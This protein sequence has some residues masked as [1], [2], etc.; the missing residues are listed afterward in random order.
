MICDR[1]KAE[2]DSFDLT[3]EALVESKEN[4]RTFFDTVD[5]IIVIASTEGKILHTNPAFFSKLGYD[6]SDIHELHLLDLH[7]ESVRKD[8]VAIFGDMLGGLRDACPLPIRTKNGDHVPVET[9]VWFGKWS[10]IDCIFGI[11]KDLSKEQEALQKFDKL[12][13][14]NPALMAVSSIPERRFTDV[15]ESFLSTL[16]FSREE[17]IGKTSAELDL[18]VQPKVQAE[19]GNLIEQQG[20]VRNVDMKVRTKDARILDGLFSGDIIESQGK[21]SFLTVMVDI[22]EMKEAERALQ[23]AEKKFRSLFENSLDGIFISNTNGR[24]L[25]ANRAAC[26]LLEMGEDEICAIGR[27]EIVDTTESRFNEAL[28]V[29]ERTGGFQGELTFRKS[30]GRNFPV[31]VSSASIDAPSS[32]AQS[33][34]IFRDIT[35]RK[36]MEQERLEMERRLLQFQKLESLW[37]MAGGIAHDFNNL[38][39]AAMGNLELA[40]MELPQGS[41]LDSNISTAIRCIQRA[42]EISGK[43]LTYSGNA[44]YEKIELKLNDL[45]QNNAQKLSSLV[46]LNATLEF[47]LQDQLPSIIGDKDHVLQVIS[48]LVTNASEA[49]QGG[50][51]RIT[52]TTSLEECDRNL[53]NRS[54]LSQKPEPGQYV[55]IRVDDNGYGMDEKTISRLFDPFFRTKFVGRG[56]GLSTV[57]GI[58]KAHGGAIL[59]E[60]EVGRGSSISVLFPVPSKTIEEIPTLRKP[61][62][63]VPVRRAVNRKLILVI[64]DEELV[65][66]LIVRMVE[67]L[68]YGSCAAVNGIHGV[69]LFQKNCDQIDLVLLDLTMPEIDGTEVL[70]KLRVIKPDVRVIIMSGFNKDQ[71]ISRFEDDQPNGFVQKPYTTSE[72]RAELTRVIGG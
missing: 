22:T 17:I 29:R 4:F 47:S 23:K 59:V 71:T 44:F 63:M 25:H 36:R 65:R 1:I 19:V 55:C 37:M 51:G 20:F 15:N 8:A 67:H 58:M 40:L 13:M 39:H 53:L 18:F 38:F 56:L 9:R 7:P 30:D 32:D 28:E 26:S 27:S 14:C 3:L 41:D 68:G 52:M 11:C 62:P 16:G 61:I 43:M 69:E 72:L 48:Q 31:D 66:D 60:S 24:I 5:D 49:V 10:G 34:V 54:C 70:R 33:Y 46:S 6:K 2:H 57:M 42:S 12:F 64:E 50:V 21:K 45:I 35:E